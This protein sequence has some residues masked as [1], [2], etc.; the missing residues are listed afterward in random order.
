M[1][2]NPIVPED[3]SDGAGPPHDAVG[4]YLL[5]ALPDDESQAF[6]THL[7]SCR[8]CLAAVASLSPVVTMLPRLLELDP[9]PIT[10]GA[11]DLIEPSSNLRDRILAGARA[12]SAPT[13]AATES[14]EAAT[15]AETPL[16]LRSTTA[17]ST[18]PRGRIRP[19]V[20]R[21]D[22]ATTRGT[23]PINLSRFVSPS[24][25]AAAVLAVVA[26]GGIV[27]AILLQGRLDERDQA[28][29]RQS[30]LIQTQATQLDDIRQRANATAYR[31]APTAQGPTGATGNV[32]YSLPDRFGVLY[33]S[34]LPALPADQDY[35]VWYLEGDQAKPGET[36]DMNTEG[37]GVVT[38]FTD[39][40]TL[41]GVALTAEPAG[42]SEQPTSDVLL[43]ATVG[44]AA[45]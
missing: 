10:A 26:V 22:S 25:L 2:H 11:T 9:P 21:T 35:Q 24:W 20:E 28:I 33:V 34:G 16:P 23:V 19:G 44:G 40:A 1:R 3:G 27:W 41:D 4:A 7:A 12:E 43:S 8:E 42:G 36:F 31:L 15:E 18:R 45:G 17:S 5:D 29:A 39:V 14:V 13:I 37:Q 38:F 32:L 30:E 6:E